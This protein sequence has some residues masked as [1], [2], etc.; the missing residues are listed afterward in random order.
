MFKCYSKHA[1]RKYF[2]LFMFLFL[3]CIALIAI[4]FFSSHNFNISSNSFI[5]TGSNLQLTGA[6]SWGLSFQSNSNIPIPNLSQQ[7]LTPYNAYYYDEFSANSIYLTFDCGYENG[8]TA[9][10]LDALKEH[11]VNASFFIVGSYI[12]ENPE[13]VMRMVNEGHVVGSHS[14]S[15][16][17][18]SKQTKEDFTQELLNLEQAFFDVTNKPLDKFYRPPEGKFTVEN[19]QWAEELQYKTVLWSLAYTDWKVDDQPTKEYALSKL[20]P[21]IHGGAIVLLHNTSS[22]NAQ[23]LSE[24]LTQWSNLGYSFKNLSELGGAH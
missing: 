4:L 14:Y 22:T 2:C 13:L 9:L 23:I 12:N 24:L 16:P 7:L 19:L 1:T 10:I 6:M 3:S 21:R 18:M 8:N 11:N 5:A 20:L 17:N 15:H